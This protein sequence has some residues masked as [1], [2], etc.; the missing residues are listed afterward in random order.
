MT[1]RRSDLAT[2]LAGTVAG[3]VALDPGGRAAMAALSIVNDN[4]PEFSWAAA[5]SRWCYSARSTGA[6]GGALLAV[7][8]RI[9]PRA[10]AWARRRVWI[11][12]R[13][14]RVGK[15]DGRPRNRR[16]DADRWVDDLCDRGRRLRRVRCRADSLANAVSR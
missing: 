16:G 4:R 1:G 3:A 8:R 14:S 11:F 10:G 2:L 6:V 9:P 15:L 13:V 5:P 12:T 7:V